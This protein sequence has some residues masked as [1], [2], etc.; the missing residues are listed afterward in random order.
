M[1]LYA[2]PIS[3]LK[4]IHGLL[5]AAATLR[6]TGVDFRLR[7]AGALP[8]GAYRA[9]LDTLVQDLRLGE[10]VE[11]LGYL[12]RERL[13]DEMQQARC[14]VLPSFQEMAPMV[15]AE[16]QAVG[17][18]VVAAPVGGTPEM[19]A[20]GH[21]GFLVDPYRPESI[22]RGLRPLLEDVNLAAKMGDRGR[23]RALVQ[24]PDRVA[25]KTLDVYDLI[26]ANGTTAR[27]RG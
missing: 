17:V 14:L 9:T 6:D 12:D 24:R 21:S 1:V 18:P 11:F 8:Q 16:A 15:V 7:L 5:R 3:P 19:V 10:Y 13:R 27:L 20:D 23:A 2:G 26:L 4:N 25:Q 22:A